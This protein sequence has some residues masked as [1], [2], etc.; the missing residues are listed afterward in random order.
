[1]KH[2]VIEYITG[3]D[4]APSAHVNRLLEKEK[5]KYKADC[6][7]ILIG[8]QNYQNAFQY[9]I[10][11]DHQE[12]LDCIAN[13]VERETP[14]ARINRSEGQ[15]YDVYK[16]EIGK[17]IIKEEIEKEDFIKIKMLPYY[18][19][20]FI[21]IN[22]ELK[23]DK[24]FENSIIR[25]VLL[26]DNIMRPQRIGENEIDENYIHNNV[27]QTMI[28]SEKFSN[29]KKDEIFFGKIRYTIPR[30]V[31]SNIKNCRIVCYILDEEKERIHSALSSRILEKNIWLTFRKIS[32]KLR[33][34]WLKL[35]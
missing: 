19:G 26:E 21:N 32:Q 7:L 23:Y 1:M 9:T 8:V 4:C 27:F 20:E 13:G 29:I 5:E 17:E 14:Y 25:F 31:F 33:K 34:F 18:D 10:S 3:L 16:D 6:E 35:L 28:M 11:E 24:E 22:Y 15:W 30:R 12:L 2:I